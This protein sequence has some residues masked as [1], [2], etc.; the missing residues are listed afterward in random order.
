MLLKRS[1][2]EMRI[3]E[4]TNASIGCEQHKVLKDMCTAQDK[5]KAL[6]PEDKQKEL[7]MLI[8]ELDNAT[9]KTSLIEQE[10]AYKQGLNDGLEIAAHLFRV[11]L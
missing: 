5:I 2:I 10:E 6:V 8:T 4:V 7:H 1:I 9:G 11:R 3:D